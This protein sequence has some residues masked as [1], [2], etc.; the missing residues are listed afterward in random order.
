MKNDIPNEYFEYIACPVC[1]SNRF[2]LFLKVKYRDLKQKPSLDYG[3]LGITGETEFFVR[4]CYQC[5][6]VF[7][8]PRVKR[9][10]E[11]LIYNECK[12][13]LYR[14]KPHLTYVNEEF[15]LHARSRKIAYLT[16]LLAALN[17]VDNSGPLKLFDYGA[18]FGHSMSL[19][20]ELGID[21]YGVDIDEK[22][23]AVCRSLGLNV[24][25]PDDFEG[26]FPDVKADI[27]LMQSNIE[28]LIDLRGTL[29]F[30]GKRCKKNAV[31]YVNGPTP[32]M[33]R[34][35]QR[36]G[37]FVKAHF[38]EH[39]NYFPPKTLDRFMASHG[40]SPLDMGQTVSVKNIADLI[41]F[42]A[43]FLLNRHWRLNSVGFFKKL[44]LY[45]G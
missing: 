12:K 29:S 45:H 40:F 2:K 22:R 44:Y 27:A 43:R 42:V 30:V 15:F 19:A 6:L 8:N 31:L 1:A 4:E 35:E 20:R 13:S 28:H 33:I 17:H 3:P 9:K 26:E 32:A 16:P 5:K 34:E 21:A 37:K 11:K 36:K 14:I 25:N 18:G 10:F 39:I 41:K 23:L 7:V 24:C 38:V